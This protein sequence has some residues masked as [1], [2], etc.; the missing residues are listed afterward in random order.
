MGGTILVVC[1]LVLIVVGAVISSAKH[2]KGEG[3]CCGGGGSVKVKGDKIKDVVA[4]KTI[5]IEGMHC[6]NCSDRVQNALNSLSQ[7]NAK[8]DLKKKQAVVKLGREVSD[9]ELKSCVERRGEERCGYSVTG[10][11]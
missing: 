10:I 8:V 4:V 9:D 7:V 11:G 1:I 2:F 5:Y 6:S 3:G